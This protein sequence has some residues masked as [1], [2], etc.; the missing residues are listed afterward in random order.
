[1]SGLR[2]LVVAGLIFGLVPASRA[3]FTEITSKGTLVILVSADENP[4][5]FNLKDSGPPGFERAVFETFARLHKLKL[6]F[7]PVPHWDQAIP[8]LLKGRGD[9]IAGINDTPARRQRIDFTTE[10]V[11]SQHVVVTRK[12]RSPIRTVQELRA[13]HVGVIPGTTWAE[14][15]TAAGVPPSQVR[16]YDDVEKGLEGLKSSEITATVMD[17]A[18]F[19]LQRRVD[20]DLQDGLVLGAGLSGAWGVR[21]T[22]PELRHQLDDFLEVLKKSPTWS[23]IV[24]ESFGEDA[25]RILGRAHN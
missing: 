5:W 11:P 20:G 22:D 18:D 25:L 24:V 12:P 15:V 13:A 8:D 16:P 19:L 23:R 9:V 14:A 1:M 6:E 7:V 17:V 3:D 2:P 4:G 21:K 10:L